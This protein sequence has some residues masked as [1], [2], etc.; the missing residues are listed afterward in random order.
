MQ[1]ND[2][3]DNFFNLSIDASAKELIK[4]AA[5]WA[6]IIAITGFISAS[7]SVLGAIF[8]K[9]AAGS[10][11]LYATGGGVVGALIIGGL[12]VSINIFLLRFASHTY[13]SLNTMNQEEFNEGISNLRVYFKF[14]GILILIFFSLFILGML[15]FI[16][17]N[18]MGQ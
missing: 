1:T 8:N 12:T 4:T 6:K 10:E 5:S 16:L 18:T 3:T 17:G 9:P 7:L 11:N 14:L 15:F 13:G 2:N